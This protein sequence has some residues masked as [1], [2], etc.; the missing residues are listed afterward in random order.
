MTHKEFNDLL[1]DTMMTL[2]QMLEFKGG[3]YAT[4]QDRFHNFKTAGR[5]K[6]ESPE[7]ACYGMW[8]KQHVSLLDMV[9]HTDDDHPLYEDSI[10]TQERIDEVI[11]DLINYHILLKGMLYERYGYQ[12]H[13]K[14]IGEQE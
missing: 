3:Q 2:E 8:I 10:P 5:C 13:S 6:A 7:K 1:Q 12:P 14:P 11:H 9:E 4:E